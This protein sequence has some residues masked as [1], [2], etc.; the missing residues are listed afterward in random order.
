MIDFF[1][2]RIQKPTTDGVATGTVI[3]SQAP[4][5]V[6]ASYKGYNLGERIAHAEVNQQRIN[7]YDFYSVL[8]NHGFTDSAGGSE[9]Q[10]RTIDLIEQ[11]I[12]AGPD[13]E[14]V[15]VADVSSKE[16]LFITKANA[17]KEFLQHFEDLA[18]L[19]S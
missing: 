6:S 18:F 19:F 14:T 8:A 2:E 12:L 1:E 7:W 5:Q 16:T 17:R 9:Y 3:P 10:S 15:S 11:N 4:L 13:G